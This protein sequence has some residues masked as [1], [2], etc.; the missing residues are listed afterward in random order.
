MRKKKI[1]DLI[2]ILL[3]LAI[4][5]IASSFSVNYLLNYFSLDVIELVRAILSFIMFVLFIIIISAITIVVSNKFGRNDRDMIVELIETFGDKKS[6]VKIEQ[7]KTFSNDPEWQEYISVFEKRNQYLIDMEDLRQEFV[8]NVSHEFKTPITSIIG[9]VQLAQD[10]DISNEEKKHYLDTIES[11]A[12]RISKLSDNLLT[13][14]YLESKEL[15]I[16]KEEYHLDKQISNVID[17]LNVQAAS[18]DIIFNI[19]LENTI[20]NANAQLISQVLLNLIDNAIKFSNEASLIDI[21]LKDNILKITNQ[22]NEIDKKNIKRV[23]ERFYMEDSSRTSKGSTGLGL[24]IT[25]K[26]L[27]IHKYTI[28][29]E[30]EEGNTIF[31]V[32]FN[33]EKNNV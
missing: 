1:L 15:K 24:A 3:I 29:L 19:E 28:S 31:N 11:E 14:T 18:K 4:L 9:F 17:S 20:I 13:L 2:F 33:V 26:I 32:D 23:F 30:S 7:L 21:T 10:N 22:G 5:Y 12:Y 8:S 27:D 16:D 6:K 25:K